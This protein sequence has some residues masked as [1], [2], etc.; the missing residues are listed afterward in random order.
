MPVTAHDKWSDQLFSCDLL[1]FL[2]INSA[3]SLKLLA[4]QKFEQ[5]F[6]KQTRARKP[7]ANKLEKA[8]FEQTN[9]KSLNR[10]FSETI[11]FYSNLLVYLTVFAEFI[12]TIRIENFS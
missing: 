8:S 10:M 11:F 7:K 4:G 5:F 2:K 6:G 1:N 3:A 12:F 9:Q